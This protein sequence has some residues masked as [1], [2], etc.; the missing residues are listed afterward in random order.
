MGF[1]QR[2]TPVFNTS[3]NYGAEGRHVPSTIVLQ[4]TI[5][6]KSCNSVAEG[7]PHHRLRQRPLEMFLAQ[8]VLAE[9]VQKLVSELIPESGGPE[10]W[11]WP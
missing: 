7:R 11:N 9:E 3:G 5:F 8:K 10:T 4:G 1:R 6:N 2:E